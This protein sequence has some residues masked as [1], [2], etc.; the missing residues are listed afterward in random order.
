MAPVSNKRSA[1]Q[2]LEPA[3]EP[4][5]KKLAKA[6]PWVIPNELILHVFGFLV[7][8]DLMQAAPVSRLFQE[9]SRQALIDRAVHYVSLLK[10]ITVLPSNQI[11]FYR[12]VA[13]IKAHL[14]K[15][16]IVLSKSDYA[17][18][19]CWKDKELDLEE[20]LRNLII[21]DP[22]RDSMTFSG[23]D[24]Y[25]SSLEDDEV[26][27]FTDKCNEVVFRLTC[28]L[29]KLALVSKGSGQIELE[30]LPRSKYDQNELDQALGQACVYDFTGIMSRLISVGASLKCL[31]DGD[32]DGCTN[33]SL[34][35]VAA[36]HD[37]RKAVDWLLP[38]VTEDDADFRDAFKFVIDGE[39]Q[40]F[41]RLFTIKYAEL[42]Q[43][44]LPP[45]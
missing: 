43:I 41:K 17:A 23:E 42:L 40:K 38:L 27:F 13:L 5:Q 31:W 7:G 2:S 6:T 44:T 4:P 29:D 21:P 35:C 37:A 9:L 22:E 28:L 30:V 15:T 33:Y 26:V 36:Y 18:H 24:I 12:L 45:G 11:E 39:N 20:T 34:L 14:L 1:P 25:K 3:Q 16:K 19:L 10:N 8:K 32:I